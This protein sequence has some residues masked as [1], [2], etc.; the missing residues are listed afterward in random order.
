MSHSLMHA[1]LAEFGL[2]IFRCMLLHQFS[3]YA[4]KKMVW[5]LIFKRHAKYTFSRVTYYIHRP[6][7]VVDKQYA[8][9]GKIV[10]AYSIV[11]LRPFCSNITCQD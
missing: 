9:H 4:K 7:P 5:P 2:L 3:T 6:K 1:C 10:I 11:T 8:L